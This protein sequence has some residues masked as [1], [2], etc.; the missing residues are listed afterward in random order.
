M[1]DN[2]KIT[3]WVCDGHEALSASGIT[4]TDELLDSAANALD[5]A[6]SWDI[7]GEILFKAEDGEYYVGT[8]DF[9]ISKANPDYVADM[10][11]LQT[12]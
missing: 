9:V 6:C 1:S 11:R 10:I 12:N 2:L 5:H 4:D 8:V 3:E 7:M